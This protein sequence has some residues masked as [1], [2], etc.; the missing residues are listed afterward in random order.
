M[1]QVP[2]KP[3]YLFKPG[4]DVRGKC[5]EAW[6]WMVTILQFWTDEASIA[7][8]DLFG[9]R[10]HPVSTLAEYVMTTVNPILP[11]GY[12]VTWDHVITCTPWMKKRLFGLTSEE[13]RRMHCQ[14]IPV[15]G[16]SS[17]LEVTMEK[18]YNECIMDT[19]AQQKK[20]EQQEKPGPKSTPSSKPTLAKGKGYGKA[21]K[22]HL[23]KAA[24]GQGWTPVPPKDDGTN[25][26]KPYEAPQCQ[27]NMEASQAG[28]SPLTDELLTPGEDLTTVLDGYDIPEEHE[29]AQAIS[30]I[31]PR[32]D[33]V[34]VEMEEANVTTGFEPEVGRMGYDVNKYG[35]RTIPCRGP[36]PWLWHRRVRCWRRI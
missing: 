4:G 14:P 36:F 1:G 21:L 9:G 23:K 35:I 5:S 22:I 17:V 13:E 3:D 32:M 10:S 28:H 34:D 24:P 7:D 20:K 33:T 8:G 19:A 27:K 30:S 12:K 18:C 15:V 6:I 31:L 2:N 16:I 26:G 29:L 25:V 11:P